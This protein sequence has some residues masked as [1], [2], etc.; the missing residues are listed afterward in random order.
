MVKVKTEEDKK[1]AYAALCMLKMLCKQGE[2]SKAQFK[3]MVK[4]CSNHF[5]TSDFMSGVFF[6][7]VLEIV[8]FKEG[9]TGNA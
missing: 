8:E 4:L 1:T 5:D 2:L 6:L 7:F 3:E 9:G